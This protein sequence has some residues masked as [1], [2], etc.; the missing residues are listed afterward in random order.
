MSALGGIVVRVTP[1]PE[2]ARRYTADRLRALPSLIGSAPPLDMAALPRDP[3]T[4]FETWLS[5]AIELGVAEP[6]AATLATLDVD[7]LPDARTLILKGVDDRGW[8]FA[9]PRSSRKAAQLAAHPAAALNFWWQPLVRAVRVR[10]HVVEADPHESAAD[11]AARSS[12]ARDG[13]DPGDWTLWRIVPV[14]VEFWQGET[15]RRHSRIVYGAAA[16]RWTRVITG[17]AADDAREGV[18]E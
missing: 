4:L 16:D 11:F 3:V 1:E 7:G 6:L 14:R 10:G 12:A 15:D 2:P 17:K 18:Q 13:L 9:G 5:E 8:A